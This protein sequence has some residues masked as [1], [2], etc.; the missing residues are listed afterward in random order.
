MVIGIVIEHSTSHVRIQS[1]LVE[2]FIKHLKFIVRPLFVKTKLIASI[3]D[4]VILLDAS[5]VHIKS[6]VYYPYSPL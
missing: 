1:G 2:S 4:N 5:L 6:I 3:W